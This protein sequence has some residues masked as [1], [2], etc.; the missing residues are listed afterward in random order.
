MWLMA[1]KMH[2]LYLNVMFRSPLANDTSQ[3]GT[4]FCTW[5]CN[6]S[7]VIAVNPTWWTFTNSYC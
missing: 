6:V 1:D 4:V 3:L 7:I 2:K 5:L